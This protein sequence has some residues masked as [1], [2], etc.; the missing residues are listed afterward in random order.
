VGGRSLSI[1][2]ERVSWLEVGDICVRG[3]GEWLLCAECDVQ[4]EMERVKVR[5]ESEEKDCNK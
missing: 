3:R 1:A 5:G 2:I 4:N